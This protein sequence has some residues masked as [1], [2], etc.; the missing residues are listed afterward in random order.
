MNE[1]PI[2]KTVLA[3]GE[4]IAAL[5]KKKYFIIIPRRHNSELNRP[6]QL[7]TFFSSVGI[8]LRDLLFYCGSKWL[9]ALKLYTI[10]FVVRAQVN[11]VLRL[12]VEAWFLCGL[13]CSFFSYYIETTSFPFCII[14]SAKIISTFSSLIYLTMANVI[15]STFCVYFIAVLFSKK[16]KLNSRLIKSIW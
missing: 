16:L 4:L 15:N 8:H 10:F 12:Y 14:F 3:C 9:L 11:S 7:L 6:A 1:I 13:I 5:N 2:K